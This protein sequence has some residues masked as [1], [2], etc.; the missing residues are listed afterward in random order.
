MRMVPAGF[1]RSFAEGAQVGGDFFE[2]R[3]D[4]C[5]QAL[6]CLCRCNAARRARQQ[7]DAEPLLE[8]A[9]RMAER[10]LRRAQLGRGSREAALLRDGQESRQVTELV[11]SHS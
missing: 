5:D 9:N 10:G 1:S 3:A 2:P 8:T 11:T 4:G 6:A 7:A